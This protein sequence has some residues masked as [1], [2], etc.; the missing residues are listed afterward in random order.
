MAKILCRIYWILTLTGPHSSQGVSI[1][2]SK[3]SF[4]RNYAH[5]RK[6]RPFEQKS[7]FF[8]DVLVLKNRRI[9]PV[10]GV[11]SFFQYRVLNLR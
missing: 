6:A 7:L 8:K 3:N 2:F 9:A 11:C 5:R 1:Q 10:S 4:T